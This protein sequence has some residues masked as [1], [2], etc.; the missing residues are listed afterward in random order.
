[1]EEGRARPAAEEVRAGA[2]EWVRAEN[3]SAPTVERKSLMS[4][5]IPA[6][7]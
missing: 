1:M 4:A 6:L 5:G 3:V 7:I 2:G